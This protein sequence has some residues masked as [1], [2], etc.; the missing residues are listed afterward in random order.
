MIKRKVVDRSRR[1][2]YLFLVHSSV[3]IKD[4]QDHA[5]D[6]SVKPEGID[7]L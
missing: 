1:C 4:F 3:K 2:Y 6:N 7:Y 5:D